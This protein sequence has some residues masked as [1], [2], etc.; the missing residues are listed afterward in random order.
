MSDLKVRP[1]GGLFWYPLDT[2]AVIEEV[3]PIRLTIGLD[4]TW[5]RPTKWHVESLAGIDYLVV[6]AWEAQ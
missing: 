3:G 4:V 2:A 5:Y 6:D 1:R